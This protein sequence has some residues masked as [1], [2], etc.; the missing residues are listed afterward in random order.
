MTR[1][2]LQTMAD[3]HRKYRQHPASDPALIILLLME[4]EEHANNY[5]SALREMLAAFPEIN[6]DELE[7]ELDRFI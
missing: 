4:T 5:C 7:T 1:S 6:R 2:E 3:S